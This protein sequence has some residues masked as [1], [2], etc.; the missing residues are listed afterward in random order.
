M[1]EAVRA[2]LTSLVLVSVLLS[3]AQSLIPPG[4]VRKAAG[5]TGV[6]WAKAVDEK[7]EELGLYEGQAE[8]AEDK[9]LDREHAALMVYHSLDLDMVSYWEQVERPDG[10]GWENR[11]L[12][13]PEK[14]G[15]TVMERFFGL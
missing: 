4:T 12:E 15:E 1:M 5:F 8:G 14:I 11:R 6:G 3:A 7:A 10:S 13:T 2:W 9:S